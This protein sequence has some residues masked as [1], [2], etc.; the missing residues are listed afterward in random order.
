SFKEGW[1]KVIS[2][3]SMVIILFFFG[4][5]GSFDKENKTTGEDLKEEVSDVVDISKDYTVEQWDKMNAEID[6]KIQKISNEYNELNDELKDKFK[7]KKAKL[8]KQ[9]EQLQ[10]KIKELN[11]VVD[12]KKEALKQEVNQ[13]KTALDESL[14]TFQKQM[15]EKSN[16]L[17]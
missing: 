2:L 6:E 9:K 16:S 13:L 7:S 4:S 5:C 14:T 17:K 10:V 15:D 8:N 11:Q 1:N 3:F 12:D